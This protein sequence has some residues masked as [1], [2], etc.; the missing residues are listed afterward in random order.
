MSRPRLCYVV[1]SELTVKA[2]LLE[3]IRAAVVDYE[4]SVVTN[5][6]DTAALRELGVPVDITPV[7]I[8]RPIAPLADLVALWMLY[9]LFR[10]GRFDLVHSVTP[11]AGLLAALAGFLARVPVRIH[12]FTGQVWATRAGFGRWLLKRIDALTATACTHVLA[13]SGSQRDFLVAEVVVAPERIAVL[14]QGSVNGVDPARFKPDADARARI[15]AQWGVAPDAVVFLYLGRLTVDKGLLDLAQAFAAV[16]GAVLA[17]VGPDEEGLTERIRAA[18]GAQ[19][20][21]LRFVGYT[22]EPQAYMAAADV[23]VLPS[24]REGFGSTAIEAAACGLP[25]IATRIYGLTDAVVDSATGYLV[26]PRNPAALA[27]R[28]RELAGDPK[29]RL[30]LGTAARERAL[31]DFPQAALTRATLAYYERKL[32]QSR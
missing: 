26:P 25:A 23:F 11:K 6:S 10:R 19:A 30:R 8:A 22:G 9:R 13:D 12:T 29:L 28:M 31:R 18:C 16:A 15:R 7:A 27:Q 32:A 17:M 4:V 5:A 3:H 24:Y 1:S 14:A 21:R 20:G 2:F